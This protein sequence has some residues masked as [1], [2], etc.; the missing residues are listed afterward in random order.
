MITTITGMFML[1]PFLLNHIFGLSYEYP[2]EDDRTRSHF[3]QKRPKIW[4]IRIRKK[5]SYYLAFVRVIH[6]W[7]VISPHKGQWGNGDAGDLRRHCVHYH[8]TVRYFHKLFKWFNM[9]FINGYHGHATVSWLL[10]SLTTPRFV[11]QLLRDNSKQM[12]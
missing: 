3:D 8:V 10:R 11:E 4:I 9:R 7:P 6:R 1:W 12:Q 2:S 5:C